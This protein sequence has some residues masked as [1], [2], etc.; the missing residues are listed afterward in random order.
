MHVQGWF[1]V[2]FSRS[3]E[4][5]M[6]LLVFSLWLGSGVVTLVLAGM[7]IIRDRPRPIHRRP[8][9]ARLAAWPRRA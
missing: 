5:S 9:T 8:V 7:L 4:I 3:L 2:P 6:L 1:P